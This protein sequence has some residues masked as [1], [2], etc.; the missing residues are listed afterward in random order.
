[1]MGLEISGI[2]LQHPPGGL[3]WVGVCQGHMVKMQGLFL[4]FLPPSLLSSFSP[5][6]P[7]F[8]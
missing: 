1:M 8:F 7:F 4:P 5:F 2:F 3:S 6:L